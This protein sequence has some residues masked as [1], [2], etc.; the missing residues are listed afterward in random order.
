MKRFGEV[1]RGLAG[2]WRTLGAFAA[3]LAIVLLPVRWG[4]TVE[5]YPILR[6][7]MTREAALIA[8]SVACVIYIAWIDLRRLWPK[9][10]PQKMLPIYEAGRFM[11]NKA[12]AELRRMAS[13]VSNGA[14]KESPIDYF[15]YALGVMHGHGLVSLHG[16]RAPGLDL[17]EI[18]K[19]YF[20]HSV[21]IVDGNVRA[22]W[23]DAPI[24]WYDL[25]VSQSEALEGLKEYEIDSRRQ[26]LQRGPGTRLPK[27]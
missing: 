25:H 21:E 22:I 18:P 2:I 20:D 12:G 3:F 9:W 8:F 10:F 24:D 26:E 5:A 7:L 4:E 23:N 13:L 15:A 1:L 11:Y 16:R 17:E 6:G 19:E 14:G 27:G